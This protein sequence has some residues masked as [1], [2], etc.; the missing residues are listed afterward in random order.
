[1]D[2]VKTNFVQGLVKSA[3]LKAILYPESNSL[4]QATLCLFLALALRKDV[5]GGTAGHPSVHGILLEGADQGH[6]YLDGVH[7][8]LFLYQSGSLPSPPTRAGWALRPYFRSKTSN[9]S[10][11]GCPARVPW[12]ERA[13]E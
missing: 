8:Q 5:Q 12:G 2:P 10:N 4:L 11:T 1:M 7:R 6:G 13:S 9:P 3:T